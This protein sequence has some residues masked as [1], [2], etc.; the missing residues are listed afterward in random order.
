LGRKFLPGLLIASCFRAALDSCILWMCE[1]WSIGLSLCR[2]RNTG[3]TLSEV[4]LGIF[5]KTTTT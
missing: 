5:P 3:A 2:I 4:R 1:H